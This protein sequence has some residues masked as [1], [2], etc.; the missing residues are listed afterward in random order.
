MPKAPTSPRQRT[1]PV[2]P[3]PASIQTSKAQTPKSQT[4]KARIKKARTTKGEAT[5]VQTGR[6]QAAENQTSEEQIANPSAA[7]NRIVKGQKRLLTFAE[8]KQNHVHSEANRREKMRSGFDRI[9]TLIPGFED[10]AR[11]ER[12][13][14]NEFAEFGTK[15][16]EYRAWLIQQVQARGGIVE[17]RLKLKDDV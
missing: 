1:K 6:D 16:L 10:R 4:P 15:K 12:L 5:I 7:E 3:Y 2:T 8:K 13:L 14:L 17:D 9:A 11:C